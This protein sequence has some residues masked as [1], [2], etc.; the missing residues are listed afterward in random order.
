MAWPAVT[1]GYEVAAKLA[2]LQQRRTERSGPGCGR[3]GE[4]LTTARQEGVAARSEWKLT[5]KHES[6]G[7][8]SAEAGPHQSCRAINKWL[9]LLI[10]WPGRV[11]RATRPIPGRL[12]EVQTTSRSVAP[13][14]EDDNGSL[15]RQDSRTTQ[16]DESG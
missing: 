14:R 4:A 7:K 12:G 15:D 2:P 16:G 9:I 11:S 6:G 10:G 13:P 8:R 5:A 1:K 3:E